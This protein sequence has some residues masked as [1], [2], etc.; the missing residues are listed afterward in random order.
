MVFAQL[1]AGGFEE[2]LF[3]WEAAWSCLSTYMFQIFAKN[4]K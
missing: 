2:L 3:Y 4:Q 1:S